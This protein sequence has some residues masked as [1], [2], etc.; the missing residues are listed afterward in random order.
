GSNQGLLG[1]QG[2]TA[3]YAAVHEDWLY[4]TAASVTDSDAAAC[5]LVGITAHLGLF[6]YG[7]I[8]AGETVYVPGGAGGVGSMVVKMAKAVGPRVATSGGKPQ[9]LEI[10]RSLGADLVLNYKIDDVPSKLREFAEEGIDVWFET[11]REPDLEV[12]IPLL[13]RRGRMILIAG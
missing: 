1:R 2:A 12:S 6:Q 9:S 4:P 5:A 7:R 13:R 11:Q 10:A 3:Q 8:K